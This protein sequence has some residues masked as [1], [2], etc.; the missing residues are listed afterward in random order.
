MR[1]TAHFISY[2]VSIHN[3]ELHLLRHAAETLVIASSPRKA[4][5]KSRKGDNTMGSAMNILLNEHHFLGKMLDFTQELADRMRR[6]ERVQPPVLGRA[7]EFFRVCLEGC[8]LTKEENLL[9]T[10]LQTKGFSRQ[11]GLIASML[12]D[13]ERGRRLVR[14]MKKAAADYEAGSGAAG[15]RWAA[16]A[17]DFVDLMRA[18]LKEEETSLFV[19]ADTLMQPSEQAEQAELAE[20]FKRLEEAQRVSGGHQLIHRMPDELSGETKER[21]MDSLGTPSTRAPSG[22][23]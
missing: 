5:D 20:E 9:F 22:A 4:E 2:L 14:E 15:G 6:G 8:L 21:A 16:A 13:H 18:H 12:V 3:L 17:L 19:M 1:L 10:K 11:T 23:I 7:G